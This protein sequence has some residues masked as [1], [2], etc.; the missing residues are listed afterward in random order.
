MLRKVKF[1]WHLYCSSL[2]DHDVELSMSPT[3]LL[4]ATLL[5]YRTGKNAGDGGRGGICPPKIRENH[6]KFGYFVNFPR[7][8]FGAKCIARCHPHELQ[9]LHYGG[10]GPELRE[11]GL[12]RMA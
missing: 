1:Y 2:Y 7:T 4:M 9:L 11:E 8:Y 10:R 12:L 6:V 3:V 5:S